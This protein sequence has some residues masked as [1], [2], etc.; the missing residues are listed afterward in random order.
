MLGKF[1]SF[2]TPVKGGHQDG[3]TF[4]KFMSSPQ[5]IVPPLAIMGLLTAVFM[6]GKESFGEPV[7]Y[8]AAIGFCVFILTV[9]TFKTLQHWND[10]KRHTSR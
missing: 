1:K 7:S 2:F 6:E 5:R 3:Y 8:Y 4:K 9:Y 10:L